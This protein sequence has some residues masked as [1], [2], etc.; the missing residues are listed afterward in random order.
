MSWRKRNRENNFATCATSIGCSHGAVSP[1]WAAIHEERLD[2]AR[3]LHQ[4]VKRQPKNLSLIWPGFRRR[5]QL[6]ANRDHADIITLLRIAFA[7]V[8]QVIKETFLPVRLGTS[9]RK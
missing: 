8:Q 7:A 3:R 1:R 5:A 2:T 4:L 9:Q 6:G